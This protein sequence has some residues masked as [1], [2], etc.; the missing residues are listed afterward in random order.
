M[1]NR[2]GSRIRAR[3]FSR[4]YIYMFF[5]FPPHLSP[6]PHTQMYS[7]VT[8]FQ[9]ENGVKTKDIRLEEYDNGKET[10]LQGYINGRPV[11]ERT[12]HARMTLSNR[13]RRR[14]KTPRARHRVSRTDIAGSNRIHKHRRIAKQ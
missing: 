10:I 8:E 6:A 14:G 5:L 13:R 1:I 3:F 2:A 9:S 11:Y 12:P 7:N 4:L